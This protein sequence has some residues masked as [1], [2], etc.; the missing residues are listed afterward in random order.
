MVELP[1]LGLQVRP[2]RL[3]WHPEDVECTVLVR[4]F[5][6]GALNHLR[7]ELRVLRLK[8]VRDVLEEDQ[9]E[10]D[11]LVLGGVHAAA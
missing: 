9:A 1:C 2:A 6:I 7:F 11:V 5:R 4:V 8:S 3:R 10:H